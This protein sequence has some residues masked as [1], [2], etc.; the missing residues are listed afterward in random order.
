MPRKPQKFKDIEGQRF[1]KLVILEKAPSQK[2]YGKTR[3][4]W[5]AKCD[6][7]EI[8]VVP[9]CRVGSGY[10]KS[11]GCLCGTGNT[12]K[13]FS[14]YGEIGLVYWNQ[15][16]LGAESRNLEFSITIEYIWDLFIKQKG[17]CA[18]SNLDI[19]FK[20]GK[21]GRTKIN[22]SLDRIDSSIG[23]VEGNVQ[24]VHKDVN[25]MK[26]DFEE[27]YFLDLCKKITDFNDKRLN[28]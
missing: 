4:F 27:S 22:A 24:W 9:T 20:L 21:N 7:G 2:M 28:L 26:M 6:C 1:D 19:S 3:S 18:L 14:G 11:C 10:L 8:C 13:N 23:Y 5:K 16:K 25:K 17:K 12:N 15:I